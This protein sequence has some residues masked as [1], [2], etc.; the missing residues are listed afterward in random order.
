M[1]IARD[2]PFGSALHMGPGF[3]PSVLGGVLI[4][5]GICIMTMGLL[6]N[7]QIQ[8]RL[9]I[10]ALIMLPLSLVLF[11]VLM[12]RAGFIPALLA[13]VLVAAASGREFRVVEVL[14]CAAVLAG[15]S[16]AV[17]VWGL[18]LSYPLVKGF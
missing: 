12:Q 2:Y 6:G 1:F 13:L 18:G 10:R 16:V 5:F 15:L 3:F 8:A 14:L 9:S 4:A 11:G 7:E 17:F